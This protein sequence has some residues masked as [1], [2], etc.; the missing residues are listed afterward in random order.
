MVLKE[1]IQRASDEPSFLITVYFL[2]ARHRYITVSFRTV[3]LNV[4]SV[5]KRKSSRAHISRTYVYTKNYYFLS[6]VSRS[7]PY[8]DKFHKRGKV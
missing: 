1:G 8:I 4:S 7:A 5:V 2:I 6:L 3:E